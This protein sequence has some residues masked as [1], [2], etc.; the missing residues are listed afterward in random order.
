MP[1]SMPHR[2]DRTAP[3]AARADD[4]ANQRRTG[5]SLLLWVVLLVAVIMTAWYFVGRQDDRPADPVP[6]G[7][8]AGE[9]SR[10]PVSAPPAS[11]DT[12]ARERQRAAPAL[13]DRDALPLSQ[14]APAYPAAAQRAGEQGTVLLQV[15]VGADGRPDD[16]SLARRSGS[17][18]LDRA[19]LEAVRGWTFEPATRNGEPVASTVQVPVEFRLDTI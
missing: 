10:S 5:A 12:P 1:A 9:T 16:V 11:R 4:L 15:E 8:G 2:H 3:S 18:D 17:R 7:D 13:P 19:A 14:P 6:I